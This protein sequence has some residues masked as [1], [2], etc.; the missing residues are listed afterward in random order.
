MSQG[1]KTILL[2][3]DEAPMREFISRTLRS[4]DYVVL[5]GA[6]CEEAVALFQA[7][8][9]EID[10]M[11]VDAALPDRNGF[12]LT[13]ALSQI[14]PGVRVLFTSGDVGAQ[15]CRFYGMSSTDVRFLKKPFLA[16]ELLERVKFL[17]APGAGLS[18]GS[19][20]S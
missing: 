11:L 5:E 16:I 19:A 4:A 12:E 2:V 20:S 1:I 6:T 8:S 14:R 15:L 3:D 13:R 9:D 10:L 7:H 17:L 18:F